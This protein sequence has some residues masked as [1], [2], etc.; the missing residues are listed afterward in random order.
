MR[1]QYT[2][3][4]VALLP[5]LS[6]SQAS[7]KELPA[8]SKSTGNYSNVIGWKDARTPKAPAGFT[9]AKYADGFENPRWMYGTPNGDVL[10]AE[11]NTN[12]SLPKQIGATIIGAGG[13]NNLKK[14]ADRI[15][16]LRD[17]DKDGKPD[18]RETFL[19]NGLN[20]P[21][22]MLVIGK[23][24]YVA[25][26]DALLRFP[27]E[28]GQMKITGKPEKIAD[29]PAGKVNQHWT[30]NLI[31]N[32]DNSKIYVAVGC[33]T[34]IGEKGMEHE[35]MKASILEMNPDGSGIRIYA[36]G[37]RNPVGM[38]WAPG[39]KTLWTAVNERDGLGDELVP[40]YLTSVKENGFYGWPYSYWGNHIDTRVKEIK[41]E[42]LDNVVVPDVD[43]GSHTA[44][45]G[46]AFYTGKAFPEKYRNGA[47]IAQHGS[48]NRKL[49]SGYKVVFVPFSNGKAAGPMEDFLTG[50]VEDPQKDEV[51][52]R[53]TGII[54]LPDGSLLLTDDKT[55]TIWRISASGL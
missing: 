29:L 22:G 19:T 27:Y 4:A 31:A 47:F 48:W 6:W 55:N 21:F 44:S 45:L 50:F 7:K 38:G 39:T 14:S 18:T 53:P 9:V 30:R 1:K 24:F 32:S 49:L 15:T 16:I 34:N 17:T 10:V 2:I 43:L 40:D 37:L 35:I 51:Y 28:P 42:M 13:S 46:L 52:G 3:I 25:N 36:S 41:P 11:S 20:Q 33:G 12:Y 54:M 8:P 5:C 26:T 23:W